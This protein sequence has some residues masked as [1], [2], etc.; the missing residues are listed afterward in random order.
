MERGSWPS[1]ILNLRD[2][3]YIYR[4]FSNYRNCCDRSGREAPYITMLPL[5]LN[6]DRTKVQ[7]VYL[8]FNI[9]CARVT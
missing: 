9:K 4:G 2:S 6:S 7:S 3:C 8:L 5:G 1:R